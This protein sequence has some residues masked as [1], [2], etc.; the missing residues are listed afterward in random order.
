MVQFGIRIFMNILQWCHQ[1]KVCTVQALLGLL[2]EAHLWAAPISTLFLVLNE[3]IHVAA[4]S[5]FKNC[6][7]DDEY[8]N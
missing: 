6:S 3:G 5:H 2:L 8:L 1:D 4:T 7:L